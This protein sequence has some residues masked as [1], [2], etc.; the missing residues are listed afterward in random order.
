MAC[1]AVA[2]RIA[3]VFGSRFGVGGAGGVDV[4]GTGIGVG[5]TGIDVGGI[6]VG[7]GTGTGAAHATS[8]ITQSASTS[9]PA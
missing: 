6:A 7:V 4:G 1:G 5:G 8:A 2:V 3:L 9:A